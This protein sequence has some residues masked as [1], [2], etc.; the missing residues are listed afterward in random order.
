[1]SSDGKASILEM[2]KNNLI[3]AEIRQCIGIEQ[4]QK[5]KSDKVSITYRGKSIN[6]IKDSSN[7]DRS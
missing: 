6:R 4:G 3:K 1:M 7:N 2:E 5:R